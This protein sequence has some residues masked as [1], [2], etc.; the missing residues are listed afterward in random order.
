M[1]KVSEIMTKDVVTVTPDLEIAKA[2]Q[3]LLDRRI[4][5]VPVVDGNGRL[6][7]IL[8]QSDIIATQKR[9]PLPSF[10]SLLDGILP[11]GSGRM[12]KELAKMSAATVGQ[13]MTEKPVFVAPDSTVEEAAT[14]MVEKKFH[15][16]PVVENGLL[17]GVVGKED[18]LRTMVP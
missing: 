7:G 6:V 2:A 10:F 18:V 13:A 16:L 4:N 1:R 12:E 15:T 9:F 8:C 5:G 11:I 17:V 3:I 14:L